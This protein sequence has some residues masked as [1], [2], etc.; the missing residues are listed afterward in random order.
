M[1]LVRLLDLA[2][3][4]V[5]L[6]VALVWFWPHN[7]EID[8]GDGTGLQMVTDRPVGSG[9]GSS[10]G[11]SAQSFSGAYATSYP[12]TICT[13]ASGGNTITIGTSQ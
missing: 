3:S 2:F 8:A 7:I 9:S 4:A 13:V 6:G 10:V 12:G 1:T 11:T 5:L